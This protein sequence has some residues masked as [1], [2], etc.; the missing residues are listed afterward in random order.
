MKNTKKLDNNGF[1]L[2]ELIIVIAIMAILTAVIGSQ[3]IPYMEKSRVSKDK[4]TLDTVY[5][6]FQTVSADYGFNATAGGSGAQVN[7]YPD[8]TNF[9]TADSTSCTAAASELEELVG[10][11]AGSLGK[12][13]V[14]KSSIKSKAT[15]SPGGVAFPCT[16]GS[17]SLMYEGNSKVIAVG[18]GSLVISNK[19]ITFGT[20]A[21]DTP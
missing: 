14:S 11:S 13:W 10:F 21:A 15:H 1:S 6:S 18:V 8:C 4:S 20:P 19:D 5:T 9:N 16:A 7:D 12:K 2:V 17:C 3:V